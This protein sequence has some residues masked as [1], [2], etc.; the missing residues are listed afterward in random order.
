[1]LYVDTDVIIRLFTGDD[2]KKQ[3]AAAK[4]FEKVSNGKLVLSAPDTAIADVVY[5]LSS[6]SLYHLPRTEIR[7]LL[8][9]LLRYPKFKVENKQII[10]RALDYY[11]DKNIDFGDAILA[12]LTGK[13]KEK[14]IYS[15]DRDFDKISN[16][17][18]KEPE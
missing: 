4:L 6:P 7:D 10:I 17:I 15:Y 11:V 8:I 3:K 2:P 13:S 12:V 16:I 5:V 9:A 14:T 18:R 1:M